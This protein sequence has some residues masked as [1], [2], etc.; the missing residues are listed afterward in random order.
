MPR[1]RKLTDL[2]ERCRFCL[3]RDACVGELFVDWLRPGLDDL[4]ACCGVEV[5]DST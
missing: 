4:E 2:S 1:K 5:R 3:A